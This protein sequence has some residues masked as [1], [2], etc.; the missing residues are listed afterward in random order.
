MSCESYSCA[1]YALECV[2][3]WI[4]L[5]DYLQT[6]LTKTKSLLTVTLDLW[7]WS[8]P[9]WF[10]HAPRS[11]L[12]DRPSCF[13]L[14]WASIDETQTILSTYPMANVCLWFQLLLKFGR[15]YLFFPRWFLGGFTGDVKKHSDAYFVVYISV[16]FLHKKNASQFGKN[17]QLFLKLI[18]LDFCSKS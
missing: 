8:I 17:K 18:I 16:Q 14:L 7:V 5:Y 2:S 15:N 12:R 9:W 11:F 6:T 3:V 10:H 4:G 13:S 1:Y